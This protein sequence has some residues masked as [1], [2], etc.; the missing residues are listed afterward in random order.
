MKP[1]SDEKR[2]R[3]I[4]VKKLFQRIRRKEYHDI[5]FQ[6]GPFV[7]CS[8]HDEAFMVLGYDT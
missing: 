6:L 3:K 4:Q 8:C 7:I 1:F 5:I 2:L